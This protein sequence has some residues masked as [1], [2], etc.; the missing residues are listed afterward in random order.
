MTNPER[1]ESATG[2]AGIGNNTNNSL[3]YWGNA[4]YGLKFGDGLL[5]S[6]KVG[7]STG[8]LPDQ[9][10]PGNANLG[11]GFDL[12]VNSAYADLYYGPWSL[13]TEYY[14]SKDEAGVSLTR[15]AK[16]SGWWV[17]PSYRLGAFEPVV[18]YTAV[19]SDGRGIA[20]GDL[21]RSAPSPGGMTFDKLDEW[22]FGVNW[23]LVGNDLKHETKFQA[24]FITSE[25]KN[26]LTG[27]ATANKLKTEGFRSQ[28]Q[29]NF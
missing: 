21:V 15:D 4:G 16:A 29:V 26:R 9:G 8:R 23:Y 2:A 19:N 10:G 25:S 27:P 18:R 1:D 28:M 13:V 7:A 5:N 24:G 11:K 12:S 3:S 6:W 22:Y 14:W 17:Q 20:P